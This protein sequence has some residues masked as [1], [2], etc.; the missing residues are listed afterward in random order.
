MRLAVH[1]AVGRILT[2]GADVAGL[3][4]A[5]KSGTAELD[6][7]QTAHSWFIGFAPYDNPQVAIAVIVENG[8][9]DVRASPIGGALLRAWKAWANL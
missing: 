7:S 9:H 2:S 5:G 4:V 6:A 8:G 3:A 1:G